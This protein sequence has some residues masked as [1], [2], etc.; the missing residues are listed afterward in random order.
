MCKLVAALEG[1]SIF[2]STMSIIAIALDRYHVILYSMNLPL[3]NEHRHNR[4]PIFIKLILIW[5]IGIVLSLPLFLV[6]TVESHYI[7]NNK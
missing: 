4:E 3:N 6:R 5:I 7:G 1:T 2:V